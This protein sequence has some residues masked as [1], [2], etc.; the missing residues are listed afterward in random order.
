MGLS[1]V[2]QSPAKLTYTSYPS[3]FNVFGIFNKGWH[4]RTVLKDE[5][6]S[7]T[8][9]FHALC[10]RNCYNGVLF[11]DGNRGDYW[12]SVSYYDTRYGCQL[13]FSS[14]SV[15]PLDFRSRSFG[16]VVRPVAEN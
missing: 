1:L 7:E 5:L 12:S 4:F 10:Y 15:Y 3:K 2:S 6:G 11:N 16:F 14:G 8:I 13:Y 9:F